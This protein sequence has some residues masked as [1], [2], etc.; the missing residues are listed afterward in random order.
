MRIKTKFIDLKIDG[1]STRDKTFFGARSMFFVA[2]KPAFIVMR[3][4]LSVRSLRVQIAICL[5][6]KQINLKVFCFDTF[7]KT[8]ANLQKA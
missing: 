8:Y 6:I 2:I 4:D 7:D 1:N 5:T 3:M